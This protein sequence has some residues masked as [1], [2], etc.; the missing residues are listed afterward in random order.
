[1]ILPGK[2]LSY[3]VQGQAVPNTGAGLIEAFVYVGSALLIGWA[4]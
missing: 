4:L 1:V 2:R 3:E